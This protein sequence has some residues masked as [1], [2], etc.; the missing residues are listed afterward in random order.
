MTDNP[1]I[2]SDRGF[3]V[4]VLADSLSPNGKRLT[5]FRVKVPRIIWPE[6]LTHRALSRNARSSRA[7][8]T[9]KFI[10]EIERD[11]FIP[12]YWGK[13]QQGMQAR[14]ELTTT[15]QAYAVKAWLTGRDHAVSTA[16]LM[17]DRGVHK[18]I[19]NRV[20]EPYLWIHGVI[21]A[22][23]WANFFSLRCHPDAQPEFR[24]AA[25]MM[26]R[27]YRDHRPT[28]GYFH[29]PYL[30]RDEGEALSDGDADDV[31]AA[32][33]ARV[34]YTPFD[35]DKADIEADLKLAADLRQARHMS[36]FEHQAYISSDDMKPSHR[37][38]NFRGWCQVRKD[39]E[40]ENATT[41]DFATL[42]A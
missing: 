29:Q 23:E 31:S 1:T 18:Q 7:V 17:M 3:E 13:N 42:E 20:L 6:I 16:R 12:I 27:L 15:E 2:L 35:Q 40:G 25:T 19:V 4:E 9:R 8:P 32:R 21:T 22:T 30:L 41:F 28:E 5:T 36:P 38:G 14:E 37:S 33:C 39:I 34:S 26:A 24:L 10:E 11:P